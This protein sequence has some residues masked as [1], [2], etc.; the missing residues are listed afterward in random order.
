MVWMGV[1]SGGVMW[2]V[3]MCMWKCSVVVVCCGVDW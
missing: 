1:A 2:C 3:V